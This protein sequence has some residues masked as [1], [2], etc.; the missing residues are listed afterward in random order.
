M[1]LNPNNI[2]GKSLGWQGIPLDFLHGVKYYGSNMFSMKAN[3]KFESYG[4]LLGPLEQ[5]IME[6]LWN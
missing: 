1:G 2:T 5:D 4:R 6:L 3:A